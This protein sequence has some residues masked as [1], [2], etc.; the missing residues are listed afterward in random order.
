MAKRRPHILALNGSPHRHGNTATLMGWVLDGCA[1]AGAAVEWLHLVDCDI[2]Y[3]RGCYGCLRTGT[4]AVKDDLEAVR[5]RLLAADGIVVGSPVYS[6]RPSAQIKTLMDRLALL[7]CYTDTFSHQ[8][9][10]GVATSHGTSTGSVAREL[11]D[12]FGQ[13]SGWIGAT[14]REGKRAYEPLASLHDQK[15]PQQVG[16]AGSRLVGDVVSP[17]RLRLP[18]MSSLRKRFV[19][20]YITRPLVL[21]HP[22]QFAA[23]I[24]AWKEKGWI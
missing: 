9:S 12:F 11:A 19:L 3:C 15:L 13:P 5:A 16:E 24:A 22:D 1:D 21:R 14:L 17:P 23:V 8:R 10:L 18:G 2:G 7:A 4:C 6:D 20:R